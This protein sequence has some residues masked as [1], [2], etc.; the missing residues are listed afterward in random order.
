MNLITV[1]ILALALSF[2]SFAVST[3]CG[4]GCCQWKWGKG[5][6]FA[7]V[8]GF[9]Q[10][11]MVFI[12]WSVGVGFHSIISEW[13][14]WI[15]FGLLTLLGLKMAIEGFKG[16]ESQTVNMLNWGKNIVLAVATSIDAI[17]A[18]VSIAFVVVSIVSGSQLINVG[19]GSLIVACVTIVASIVGLILGRFCRKGFGSQIGSWA[20]VLGGIVLIL[21][22]LKVLFEHLVA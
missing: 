19:I 13:D 4:F 12:G 3:S 22:G 7:A 1:F 2:D 11:F 18:G 9:M 21:I 15:A 17:I 10:G 8:M 14:H 6:R 16:G 20:E 5:V